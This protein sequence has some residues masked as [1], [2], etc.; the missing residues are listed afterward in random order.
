[1]GFSSADLQEMFSGHGWSLLGARVMGSQCYG[2]VE[3]E[4]QSHADEAL[5]LVGDGDP[6]FSVNGGQI[7]AS[8]ARGSMPDWKRG[9]AVLSK[10]DSSQGLEGLE[11][12]EHP[13]ARMLRLQAAAVAAQ[14]MAGVI[15]AEFEPEEGQVPVP[16]GAAAAAVAVVRPV[17]GAP[18]MR[19]LV[20]Y[21][22]L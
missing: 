15:A 4:Q 8:W 21:G 22:D 6:R 3:F 14:A 16:W 18:A 17:G 20:D 1:V 12:Y 10:R 19:A 9:K 11:A 13:M 5:A 2:F 7:R